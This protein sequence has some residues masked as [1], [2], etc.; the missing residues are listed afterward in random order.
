M[1]EISSKNQPQLVYI[2]WAWRSELHQLQGTFALGRGKRVPRMRLEEGVDRFFGAIEDHA[3]VRV[4][5]FVRV[6]EK[7]VTE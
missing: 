1:P 2:S 6:L 4:T 3:D 5:C 7:R